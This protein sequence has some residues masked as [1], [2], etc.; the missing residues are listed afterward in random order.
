MAENPYRNNAKIFMRL[1]ASAMEH[2]AEA[3]AR[4]LPPPERTVW[5]SDHDR[6]PFDVAK[7]HPERG[8]FHAWANI[9]T[10]ERVHRIAFSCAI[11]WCDIRMGFMLPSEISS[12]WHL[13]N[14][15]RSF[16]NYI[17]PANGSGDSDPLVLCRRV[18]NSSLI[19]FSFTKRFESFFDLSLVYAYDM[20]TDAWGEL[21][22][23]ALAMEFLHLHAGLLSFL[24]QMGHGAEDKICGYYLFSAKASA[25]DLSKHLGIDGESISCGTEEGQWV[26]TAR[27]GQG[28]EMKDAITRFGANDIQW[29]PAKEMA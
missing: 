9:N 28:P 12:K 25:M 3:I 21:L 17:Y 6:Q 5:P 22:G 14:V 13:D 20:A 15:A 4:P 24:Q 11:R 29:V 27:D 23:D 18:G 10:V 19:D 7:I 8:T 26:V 1:I 2:M 16:R